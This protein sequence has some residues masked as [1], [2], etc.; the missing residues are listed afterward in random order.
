MVVNWYCCWSLIWYKKKIDIEIELTSPWI[1]IETDILFWS[2]WNSLYSQQLTSALMWLFLNKNAVISGFR[3]LTSCRRLLK[4][5]GAATKNRWHREQNN[6]GGNSVF[7]VHAAHYSY[8]WRTTQKTFMPP[9]YEKR[10]R[11][12]VMSTTFAWQLFTATLSWLI[13]VHCP[14][15]TNVTGKQVVWYITEI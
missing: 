1:D 8:F 10:P 14:V 15:P 2:H 4:N 5:Q 11:V 3:F 12:V 9:H 13:A 7:F 6:S